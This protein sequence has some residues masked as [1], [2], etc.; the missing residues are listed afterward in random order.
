MS[1]R[2]LIV[3]D[4]EDIARNLRELLEGEGHVVEWASNGR[5]ALDYLRGTSN[6]PSFILLDLMMPV[7]DGYEF[8]KEQEKDPRVA[9]IPVVLMTADGYIEAKKFKV[10]AQMY[11]SKPVDIDEILRIVERFSA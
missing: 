1:A 6:L 9:W 3:E 8:R 11:V 4:D 10:G 7:M 5:V 2:I